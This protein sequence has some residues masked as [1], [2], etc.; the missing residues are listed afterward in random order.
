MP[1]SREDW[2]NE[3]RI[4]EMFAAFVKC[5][6]EK[7]YWNLLFESFD[8]PLAVLG[9]EV[10]FFREVVSG[11]YPELFRVVEIL[12]RQGFC[13][14]E[15]PNYKALRL[16]LYPR[17]AETILRNSDDRSLSERAAEAWFKKYMSIS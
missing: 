11:H 4:L 10:T 7:F 6:Y 2:A 15:R 16:T 14:W 1:S 8:A 12:R 17:I 5:G 3:D 9:D 13:Y